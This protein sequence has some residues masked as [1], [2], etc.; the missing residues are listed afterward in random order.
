MTHDKN[1][2]LSTR[3]RSGQEYDAPYEARAQ[4]GMDVHGEANL[5]EKLLGSELNQVQTTVPYCILDAGC[6][7]GR[8]SIEL[9]RR[10]V[11]IVGVDLDEVML[12]Q[13]RKKAPHL[14]WRLG[15][16]SRIDLGKMFDM[17]VMAGNVMIFLTPGSE[18][19]TLA[20]MAR[21]LR[22]GGLLVAAFELTPR[23]WTHMSTER[24]DDL[25]TQA[26]LHKVARWSTW[27]QGLW[28]VGDSYAVS[29]HRK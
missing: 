11:E 24:Y 6:G 23:A 21:H 27:D 5:V 29:V 18:A 26:G 22:P 1:P 16:L 3:T 4:A 13:A 12:S 15:D 17:V 7:T 9:A 14:D 2:W 8:M 28:Q 10:G 19:A 25:A 20:N